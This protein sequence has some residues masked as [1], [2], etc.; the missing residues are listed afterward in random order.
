MTKNTF[1]D[2]LTPKIPEIFSS[3]QEGATKILSDFF[4]EFDDFLNQSLKNTWHHSGTTFTGIL[5]NATDII[6][7]NVGDSKT[8]LLKD[9]KINF[10]VKKEKKN[11]FSEGLSL[12]LEDTRLETDGLSC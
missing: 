1:A 12:T 5:M 7:L 3:S 4:Y 8:Y 11:N 10:E 9:A 2:K 6:V